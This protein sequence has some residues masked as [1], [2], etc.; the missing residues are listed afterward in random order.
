ME[1]FDHL[2]DVHFGFH[3]PGKVDPRGPPKLRDSEQVS[4][5]GC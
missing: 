2:N 4:F 1:P 5:D 3:I